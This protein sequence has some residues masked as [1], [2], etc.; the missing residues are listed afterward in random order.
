M[1]LGTRLESVLNVVL[2]VPPLFV[3]DEILRSLA[4]P[5]LLTQTTETNHSD[6]DGTTYQ[7][8]GVPSDTAQLH[9]VIIMLTIKTFFCMFGKSYACSL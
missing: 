2:R 3:I 7:T 1:S 5:T 6:G 4:Y 8:G 9:K